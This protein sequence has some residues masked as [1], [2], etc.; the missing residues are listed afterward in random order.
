M[1][2]LSDEYERKVRDEVRAKYGDKVG[3][4][5]IFFEKLVREYFEHISNRKNH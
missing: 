2:S 3:G 4:L 1:I 5:S